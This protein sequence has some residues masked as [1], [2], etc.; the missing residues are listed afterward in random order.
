MMAL[1]GPAWKVQE[2]SSGDQALGHRIAG[3][4]W[5]SH[6]NRMCMAR[7]KRRARLAEIGDVER[8][9]RCCPGLRRDTPTVGRT[10][11]EGPGQ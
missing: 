4:V 6:A 7:P 1:A 10:D 3:V 9:P 2:R 5:R 8:S 11:C